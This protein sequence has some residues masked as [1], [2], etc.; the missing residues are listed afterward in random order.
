MCG[1]E[2]DLFTNIELCFST[3]DTKR[4]SVRFFFKF[5]VIETIWVMSTPS[6]KVNVCIECNLRVISVL[7]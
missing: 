5:K 1:P 3:W 6:Y 2:Y 4:D 7:L